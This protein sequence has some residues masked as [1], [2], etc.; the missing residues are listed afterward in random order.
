MA[1]GTPVIS[2]AT[3]GNREFLQDKENCL[4]FQA[5][6]EYDLAQKIVD[7]V[8]ALGLYQKLR[9]VANQQVRN[10]FSL[11]GYVEHIEEY[12]LSAAK[13]GAT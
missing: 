6:D 12:L 3:G 13:N 10:N 4:I 7:L 11:Q 1:Y 9:Q 2:T 8:S 5:R